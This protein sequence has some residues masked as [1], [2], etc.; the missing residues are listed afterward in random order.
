MVATW[1]IWFQYED[2]VLIDIVFPGG[3]TVNTAAVYGPSHTDDLSFWD[4]VKGNLDLRTSNG[5]KMILGYYNVSLNYARDTYNYLT[6]PHHNARKK[7]NQWLYNAE[8]ANVYEEL[9]PSKSS[10]T[11]SKSA[12][13]SIKDGDTNLKSTAWDKK[14]CIDLSFLTQCG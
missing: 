8:F 5:G 9:H 10:Y 7:I 1:K 13:T 2:V 14:S 11:W 6:D 4:L 12:E 3:I